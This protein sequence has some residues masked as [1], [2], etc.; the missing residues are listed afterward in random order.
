MEVSSV[1]RAFWKS[2]PVNSVDTKA[3][4]TTEFF[5]KCLRAFKMSLA[6]LKPGYLDLNLHDW[7]WTLR[8]GLLSVI[9]IGG[10]SFGGLLMLLIR[11]V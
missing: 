11:Q 9:V 10:V 8:L 6:S 7:V 5:Q 1:I 4:A 3:Q 2:I